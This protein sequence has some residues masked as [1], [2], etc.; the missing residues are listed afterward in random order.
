MSVRLTGSSE[1]KPDRAAYVPL[2]PYRDDPDGQPTVVVLPV[3]RPYG[4]W[5]MAASAID[6]S[7]PDSVGAF[8]EW[9]LNESGWTVTE[10]GTERVPIR[11]RHVCLLF[12][13]F[14]NFGTDVTNGYVGS[15]EA[16]GIPHLLVGGRTFH[17]REEV[18]T[19]RSA[20]SAI[21]WPDDQLSVFATLRGSLFAI[22]D[23]RAVRVS[24]AVRPA[25]SFQDPAELQPT[26]TRDE[27]FDRLLPI[28]DALQLLQKL[29]RSRTDVPIT[30]TIGRLLE[31]TRAHA[32]FVM[33]PAGEQALANVLQIAELARRF[34]ATGG[35]SFRGF[36][37]H[38]RQ[39]ADAGRAGEAPILEDGSDGV[40]IM[41]VHRAK[42]LEF[43]I[44]ILADPT[45]KL[46]R[47]TADRY[48][49][50]ER[51]LCALRLG[52]WQPLDLLDHQAEEVERD[53]EKVSVWRMWRPPGR[54]T[55]SSY[56]VLAM[57]RTRVDGRDRSM[58]LSTR[59]WE[60]DAAQ[61]WR[62]RVQRLAATRCSSARRVTPHGPTRS[63]PVSI[64]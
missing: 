37:E 11:P 62:H 22:E 49:D 29:H 28:A 16:R 57:V 64:I 38:L 43:P 31:V 13:R 50:A 47:K 17:L 63:R 2:S 36:V 20:L 10:S 6:R 24:P 12:R 45:G 39:E 8:V 55:S 25:P 35:L 48:V 9:L 46:H 21:E 40:R 44:V 33:R 61:S 56:P 18:A 27:S 41:T 5:R 4:V 34:E 52:G 32:G 59:P 53:R 60:N 58:T 30:A 54:E 42:G 14:E 15:L 1:K 3:P 7:L 26:A 23:Q 19:I 51:G